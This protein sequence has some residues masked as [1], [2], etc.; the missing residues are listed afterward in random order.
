MKAVTTSFKATRPQKL[1]PLVTTGLL[2]VN[3]R[4]SV[5]W[6]NCNSTRS[7][8][9]ALAERLSKMTELHGSYR[10][11]VTIE[12]RTWPACDWSRLH[13]CQIELPRSL[14]W[15]PCS[16]SRRPETPSLFQQS[17]ALGSPRCKSKTSGQKMLTKGRIAAEAEFSR[18]TI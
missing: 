3:R 18:A 11:W 12:A 14:Q 6:I 13:S 4:Y 15:V 5:L 7:L 8:S 16:F 17:R 10:H 1:S 2:G 9:W